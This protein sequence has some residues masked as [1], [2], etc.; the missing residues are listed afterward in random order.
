MS[1]APLNGHFAENIVHFG[2]VLRRAG[3]QEI[4]L[5]PDYLQ[6]AGSWQDHVLFQL[7]LH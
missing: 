1:A 7:I 5:A 6:I 2:R 4:G 3:F